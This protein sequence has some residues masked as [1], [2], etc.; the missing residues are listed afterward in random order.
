MK[1]CNSYNSGRAVSCGIN[2]AIVG[3]P[4]SGKS[5]LLNMLTDSER[6]IV[7]DIAGTTRDVI[8]EKVTV[9]NIT[10]NLADTAGIRKTDDTVE[11]IGVD[12]ALE[13]VE[14]SELI[15]A[16]IDGASPL[17]DEEKELLSYLSQ[18]QEK[19]MILVINKND[20]SEISSEKSQFLKSYENIFASSVSVSAKKGDGKQALEERINELYPS[21][22]ELLTQGLVITGARIYAAVN[23]AYEAVCDGILTLE[24]YTQDLA[25]TDIE[26]AI[27]HLSEADG[28]KVTEEIVDNIFSRFCVGK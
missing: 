7:T 3:L 14:E 13:R 23:C 9:G 22:D 1:L 10:L 16:V 5:S 6:A 11:K 2:T 4:N 20:L 8:T 25:G 17:C 26:R 24:N 21:G 12:R 27:A 15:L 19:N 18:K 28:R